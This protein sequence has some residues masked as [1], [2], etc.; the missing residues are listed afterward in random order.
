MNVRL[1][2]AANAAY[3]ARSLFSADMHLRCASMFFET[4]TA[5]RYK[6]TYSDEYIFQFSTNLSYLNSLTPTCVDMNSV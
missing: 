2:P 6:L 1:V 3:N 5:V 4:A